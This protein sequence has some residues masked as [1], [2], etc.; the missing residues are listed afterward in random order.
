[1]GSGTT[2]EAG[3]VKSAGAAKFVASLPV[4]LSW[5]TRG[6]GASGSPAPAWRASSWLKPSMLLCPASRYTSG[7]SVGSTSSTISEVTGALEPSVPI[8]VRVRVPPAG[9]GAMPMSSSRVSS[10][11]R[12][13]GSRRSS[14]NAQSRSATSAPDAPSSASVTGSA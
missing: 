4:T 11:E 7:A 2:I 6:S 9:S 3:S 8:T 12:S 14:A 1:M 13:P 5:N 10:V